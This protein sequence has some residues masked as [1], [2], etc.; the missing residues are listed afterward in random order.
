MF[1]CVK[2]ICFVACL[3]DDNLSC[4]HSHSTGEA[5]SSRLLWSERKG[6]FR[7]VFQLLLELPILE[8]DYGSAPFMLGIERDGNGLT[9]LYADRVRLKA[10]VYDNRYFLSGWC[11][12]FGLLT[13]A[14]G[15]G[16]QNGDCGEAKDAGV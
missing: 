12:W 10:I 13:K 5:V 6:S 9:G 11:G 1:F 4:I 3:L 7:S 2:Q 14:D 8:D 15:S 16:C